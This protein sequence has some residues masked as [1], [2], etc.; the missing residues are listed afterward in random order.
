[1]SI[2]IFSLNFAQTLIN[3][4]RVLTQALPNCIRYPHPPN[5]SNLIMAQVGCI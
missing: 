1:M 4:P 3:A 2:Y 5:T